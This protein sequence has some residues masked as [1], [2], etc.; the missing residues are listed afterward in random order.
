[1]T[2]S[3][4]NNILDNYLFLYIYIIQYIILIF[5]A[6]FLLNSHPQLLSSFHQVSIFICPTNPNPNPNPNFTHFGST[7]KH[8]SFHSLPNRSH[9]ISLTYPYFIHIIGR[10]IYLLIIFKQN[11]LSLHL[12]LS[13]F[14]FPPMSISPNIHL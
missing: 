8:N 12:F 7:L 14:F 5:A 10:L 4:L 1:M 13:L 6:D 9:T 3:L 2:L 11:I